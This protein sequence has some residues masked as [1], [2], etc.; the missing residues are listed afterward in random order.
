MTAYLLMVQRADLTHSRQCTG[1]NLK[2]KNK[3]T[4]SI[5]KDELV[6]NRRLG[7]PRIYFIHFYLFR[8]LTLFLREN[9]S[10]KALLAFDLKLVLISQM[11]NFP[12]Y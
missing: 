9:F 12:L 1:S 3:N 10:I 7:F 6:F 11:S 8:A 5:L 4:R 2:M